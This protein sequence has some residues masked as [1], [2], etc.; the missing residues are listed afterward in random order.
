ME[1]VEDYECNSLVQHLILISHSIIG[2]VEGYTTL[3]DFD[4]MSTYPKTFSIMVF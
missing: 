4:P 1:I 3:A 2:T